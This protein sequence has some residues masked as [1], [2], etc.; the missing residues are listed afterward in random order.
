MQRFKF[1]EVGNAIASCIA[2]HTKELMIIWPYQSFTVTSITSFGT[3]R[4]TGSTNPGWFGTYNGIKHNRID[5]AKRANVEN[6]IH[7]L[8]ALFLLNLWLRE[9]DIA[10]QS[11]H[12]N[13]AQKRITAYSQ[14][15]SPAK[16]LKLDSRDGLSGPMSGSNL[17]NLCFDWN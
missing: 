17:R 3:W 6:V 15:F 16:F 10:Q 11:E 12:I 1:P 8:G 7:A 9:A 14:F 13:L 5:N 2:I 4:Q